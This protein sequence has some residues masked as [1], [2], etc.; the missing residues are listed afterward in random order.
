[1][2]LLSVMSLNCNVTFLQMF[3]YSRYLLY[4]SSLHHVSNNFKIIQWC[5]RMSSTHWQLS[6]LFFQRLLCVL[7]FYVL[8]CFH[9]FHFLSPSDLL[10]Y[11]ACLI[12]VYLRLGR[13]NL[14]GLYYHQTRKTRSSQQSAERDKSNTNP[15]SV[16]ASV[17][18]LICLLHRKKIYTLQT[19]KHK[20]GGLGLYSHRQRHTAIHTHTHRGGG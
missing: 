6:L 17:C 13:F 7:L 15:R 10:W 16:H 3:F 20:D 18:I 12:T 19:R 5:K 1:M 8:F 11:S 4:C 9:E 14:I 2:Y